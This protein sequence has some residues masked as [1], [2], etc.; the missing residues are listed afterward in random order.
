MTGT[1]T[2]P[3]PFSPVLV[4]F[5]LWNAI[6]CLDTINNNFD[7]LSIE[8]FKKYI[9]NTDDLG[10][11]PNFWVDRYR[12]IISDFINYNSKNI[13]QDNLGYVTKAVEKYIY[14]EERWQ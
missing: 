7:R 14:K 3:R 12:Q 13:I 6:S 2:E 9:P 5:L 11:Y 4:E 10:E 8:M 1:S